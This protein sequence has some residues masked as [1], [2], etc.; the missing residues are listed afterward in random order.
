MVCVV[1]YF[2]PTYNGGGKSWSVLCFISRP[3]IMGEENHGLCCVLIFRP[4]ITG[5]E[6]HDLCCV[7]IFRPHITGEENHDLCCVLFSAHI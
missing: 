5:E 7:L 3:H 1:F 6:N 2:P 4:H